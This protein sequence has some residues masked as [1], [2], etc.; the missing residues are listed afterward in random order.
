MSLYEFGSLGLFAYRVFLKFE[1]H[2][3]DLI[4]ASE[5]LNYF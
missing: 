3:G 5:S 1:G 4:G 2:V